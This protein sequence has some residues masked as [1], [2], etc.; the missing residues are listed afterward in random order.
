MFWRI[1]LAPLRRPQ[2]RSWLAVGSAFLAAATLTGVRALYDGA[3]LAPARALQIAGSHPL[4]E[5]SVLGIL[6]PLVTLLTI[7]VL[8]TSGLCL[9]T[10]L[11]GMQIT[12]RREL[13]L[14]VAL[15]ATRRHLLRLLTGE[16]FAYLAIGSILGIAAGI[17][18]AQWLAFQFFGVA[19]AM[20]LSSLALIAVTLPIVGA[21][22]LIVPYRHLP[23][24]A[25]ATVLRGE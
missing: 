18:L 15:G 16:V 10:V 20:T 2:N 8:V 4:A 3:S 25:P 5:Q 6:S 9:S 17:G 11:V 22:S 21:V 12:R 13:A 14:L 19:A 23:T 1:A 7:A 24:V